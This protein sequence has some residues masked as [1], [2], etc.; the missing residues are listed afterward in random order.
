ML[1]VCIYIVVGVPPNVRGGARGELEGD[2]LGDGNAFDVM[3][4]LHSRQQL[5]Q[6]LLSEA[7]AE[8]ESE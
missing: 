7:V 3:P 6:R 8:A 1:E 4:P 5:S 2:Q